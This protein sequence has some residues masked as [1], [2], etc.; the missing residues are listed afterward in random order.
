MKLRFLMTAILLLFCGRL[1]DAQSCYPVFSINYTTYSYVTYL[2]S[3]DNGGWAETDVNIA[4]NANMTVG[5]SCPSWVQAQIQQ[6]INGST[7][8]PHI[9][10]YTSINGGHGGW[11]TGPSQCYNCY[12]NYTTYNDTGYMLDNATTNWNFQ[13]SMACS[14][15]GDIFDTGL[16]NW[17][18]EFAKTLSQTT[19][20]SSGQWTVTEDAPGLVET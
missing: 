16:I 19:G 9:Y 13:D 12:F 20:G 1:A 6:Q 10:N 14:M 4:G 2:N 18:F 11:T 5:G 17:P 15:G 8:Q 3:D 7:H